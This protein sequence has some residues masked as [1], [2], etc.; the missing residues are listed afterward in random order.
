MSNLAFRTIPLKVGG[1]PNEIRVK[2]GDDAGVVNVYS[3]YFG[4][5]GLKTKPNGNAYA[6]VL[7]LDISGVEDEYSFVTINAEGNERAQINNATYNSAKSSG[8]YVGR[9]RPVGNRWASMTLRVP[10]GLLKLNNNVLGIHSRSD[11]GG[12]SKT[13]DFIVTRAFLLYYGSEP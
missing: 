4:L 2:V 12:L 5:N 13:D 11:N 7:V 10:E 6:A 8:N 1:D 3:E 9:L